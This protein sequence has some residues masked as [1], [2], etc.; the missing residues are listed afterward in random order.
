MQRPNREQLQTLLESAKREK[1]SGDVAKL[2]A[3]LAKAPA[4]PSSPP[5]A[6]SSPAKSAPA[7]R[8]TE[9]VFVGFGPSEKADEDKRLLDD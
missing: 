8:K 4:S 2:E 6:F 5:P 7:E 3:L 1:R 9:R